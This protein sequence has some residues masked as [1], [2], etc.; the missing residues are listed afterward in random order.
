MI[1]N[2]LNKKKTYIFFISSLQKKNFSSERK[3]LEKQINKNVVEENIK[4]LNRNIEKKW[5][6]INEKLIQKK[7]ENLNSIYFVFL[8]GPI[9]NKK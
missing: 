4:N 3:D 9:V 6:P 8:Q 5:F 2:L 1:K 7:K